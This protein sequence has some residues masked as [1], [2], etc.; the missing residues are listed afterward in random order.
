MVRVKEL[1]VIGGDYVDEHQ[2]LDDAL[3]ALRAL[4]T[5]VFQGSDAA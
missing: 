4:R 1:F 2:I 5:G 3:Y